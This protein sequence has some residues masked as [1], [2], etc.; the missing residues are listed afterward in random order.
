MTKARAIVISLMVLLGLLIGGALL[1]SGKTEASA[2]D[3]DPPAD[4]ERAEG[5]VDYTGT[6]N[7]PGLEFPKRVRCDNDEVNEFIQ[8]FYRTCFLNEYDRFRLMMSTRVDPFTPE[9]FKRALTAVEQIEI[10]SIERLPDVE[11]VP[12]PVYLVRADVRFRPTARTE[13]KHKTVAIVVFREVG[14]WVMAPAP[15]ALRDGLDAFLEAEGIEAPQDRTNARP[16]AQAGGS[17]EIE[18]QE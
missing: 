18:P 14:N 15:A 8:E 11:D 4:G 12:P 13:D 1:F 3:G 6:E 9:R 10:V 17:L 5:L 2:E 16:Q 7:R